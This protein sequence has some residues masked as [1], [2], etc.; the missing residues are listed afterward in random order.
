MTLEELR[1]RRAGDMLAVIDRQP[2]ICIPPFEQVE[3]RA[4]SG[5]ELEWLVP[6]VAL[7]F[8][9][10]D[11]EPARM[12]ATVAVVS[13]FTPSILIITYTTRY[14]VACGETP[15]AGAARD[16]YV[17]LGAARDTVVPDTRGELERGQLT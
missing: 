8:A 2:P 9:G 17:V 15:P 16:V 1:R 12:H 13:P 6:E 14:H 3:L 5:R 11:R 10:Q 7:R 4:A